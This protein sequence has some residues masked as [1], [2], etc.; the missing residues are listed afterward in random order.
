MFHSI[1]CPRIATS[2]L[3]FP[4]WQAAASQP[5]SEKAWFF[6]L[7]K[8]GLISWRRHRHHSAHF[9]YQKVIC[10]S[11]CVQIM[12]CCHWFGRAADNMWQCTFPSRSQ[13]IF[14]RLDQDCACFMFHNYQEDRPNP[15]KKR[16]HMKHCSPWEGGKTAQNLLQKNAW[17]TE[18][19][20]DDKLVASWRVCL[21]DA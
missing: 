6:G 18:E 1:L 9:P 11:P 4:V 19:S 15:E 13:S 21:D 8:V 10:R 5:V 12:I 16:R 7:E 2:Q 14:R 20:Q 17:Y 3:P